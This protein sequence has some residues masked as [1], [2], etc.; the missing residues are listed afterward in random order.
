MRF[1]IVS[2]VAAVLGVGAIAPAIPQGSG[3]AAATRAYMVE[4]YTPST[5]TPITI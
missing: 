1:V 5:P 2:A 4:P 3:Q